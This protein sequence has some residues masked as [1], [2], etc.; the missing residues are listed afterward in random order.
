MVLINGK[1]IGNHVNYDKRGRD[2]IN[3]GIFI[4]GSSTIVVQKS[5]VINF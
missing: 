4:V 3:G 5:G 2:G 1:G